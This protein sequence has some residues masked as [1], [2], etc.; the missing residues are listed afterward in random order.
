MKTMLIFIRHGESV[1]NKKDLLAGRFDLGLTQIGE[2]QAS[3]VAKALENT[4]LT[5]VYAS[6]LPRAIKTASYLAKIHG[7]EVIQ[8]EAFAEI[9][10]GEFEGVNYLKVYDNPVLVEYRTNFVT[11][12]FPGGETVKE[13]AL[14]FYK[15]A[16]KIAEKHTGHTIAIAT[17]AA[18]LASFISLVKANGKVEDMKFVE[19][20]PNCSF[21]VCSFED[22][23]FTVEKYGDTSHLNGLITKFIR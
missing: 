20:T 9:D 2:E 15:G 17:H 14:R 19:L 23:E 13:V 18:A 4:T 16:Q 8:D 7:F 12:Q 5:A 11:G 1:A 10:C 21:T 6:N 22:G 3:L